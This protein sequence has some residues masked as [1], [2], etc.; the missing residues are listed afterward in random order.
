MI[1]GFTGFQGWKNG[2]QLWT[3]RDWS[4]CR[5]AGG[6]GNIFTDIFGKNL[7]TVGFW[8]H[9]HIDTW[10][11]PWMIL[12]SLPFCPPLCPMPWDGE[13]TSGAPSLGW[14]PYPMA[15]IWLDSVTGGL[16]GNHWV[17]RKKDQSSYSSE[18][19]CFPWSWRRFLLFMATIS[20]RWPLLQL[21]ES[22]KLFHGCFSPLEFMDD[23][24]PLLL[25]DPA[26]IT[27]SYWVS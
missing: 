4:H 3:W 10:P 23:N 11:T 22:A 2:L 8:F 15:S 20:V 21:Q 26:C 16:A 7:L 9:S 18:P 17:I 12:L 14:L 24:S 1:T 19:A 25:P 13:L 6:T 27:A 5:R